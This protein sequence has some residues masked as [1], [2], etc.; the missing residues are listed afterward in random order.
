M[1]FQP[2]PDR[3]AQVFIIS[4][5][6]IGDDTV[7]MALGDDIFAGHGLKKR[8]KAAVENAK[9][10]KGATVFSYYVDDPEHFGIVEFDKD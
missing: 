5:D 4:A 6:F 2:S 1:Q 9:S 7:A 3:L 10:G 8:L